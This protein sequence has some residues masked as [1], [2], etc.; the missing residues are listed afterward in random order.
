MKRLTFV[1][2]ILL[3]TT[4]F[5]VS[6]S[7]WMQTSQEDFKKGTL[8]NVVATNL[9]VLKLSRAVK[10]LL[11]QN[12]KISSVNALAEAPD[13]TIYA[14][15][16]PQGV[17]LQIKDQ[18]VTTLATIDGATSLTSLLV[19]KAGRLL[20]GTSGDKGKLFVLEKGKD[21]PRLLFEDEGVQYVW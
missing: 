15:T 20:I 14:G 4:A 5:A 8:E 12:P 3:A 2:A 10:T 17:L 16:G 6:T 19:D 7:T 1:A 13:G 11:D 18:K 9:G 21:K